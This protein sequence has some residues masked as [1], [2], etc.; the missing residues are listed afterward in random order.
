MLDPVV[1]QEFVKH[2]EEHKMKQQTKMLSD[3]MQGGTTG[4][5]PDMSGMPGQAGQGGA[6][7]QGGNAEGANQFSGVE[8]PVDEQQP[9]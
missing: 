7:S 2:V 5:M 9:A 3:L 8:A 6:E 1:Q 4:G